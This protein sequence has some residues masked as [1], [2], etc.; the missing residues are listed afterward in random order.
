MVADDLTGGNGSGVL[1]KNLSLNAVTILNTDGLNKNDLKSYDAIVYPTDSR[2]IE[3]ED[4]YKRV[5]DAT[6]FF[7][8]DDVKLYAKRIDSTLRGNIGVEVDAMLDALGEDY[9]SF[10][11]PCFPT[12]GRICVGGY[13]LV[14]GVALQN[15]DVAND[16]KCPISSSKVFDIL[17]PQSKFKTKYITLDSVYGDTK[18]L[19]ETLQLAA[20]EGVRNFIFDA[21]CD[22]DLDRIAHAAIDSNLKF[23]TVDAGPP[24]AAAVKALISKTNLQ[25]TAEPAN[26]NNILLSIGSVT[27][28]TRMQLEEFVS[29]KKMYISYLDVHKI[30]Y[31]DDEA[32]IE[33]VF[34]DLS[35]HIHQY[36]YILAVLNSV[37][38]E[39]R[40]DFA[41]ASK[42]LGLSEEE[43][44]KKINRAVAKLTVNLLN[45]H[46][47]IKGIFSSGGD[48][49]VEVSNHLK[50]SGL[51]LM[52]EVIPL[53][54]Y[55][56]LVGGVHPGL[57]IV[58]KGGI[59][60]G[61]SAMIECV[62]FLE[63][64]FE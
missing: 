42:K 10:I 22:E 30:V 51:A 4:A 33:R 23:I 21:I 35:A 61:R 31:Q 50:A 15:T 1:L 43:I 49:T 2:G 7:K 12:A 25:K 26:F 6:T 62:E 11:V 37:Y 52:D 60:G 32:E 63:N 34:N 9:V 28:S 41:E 27:E 56:K 47:S 5:F 45:E 48:I 59:V 29:K 14:N 40:I 16:P 24:T 38:K 39:N 3:K 54:A 53:A 55:G 58:T 20:K 44:S 13:L 8:A 18:V 57:S 36:K 17:S 19:I 64:S 46:E